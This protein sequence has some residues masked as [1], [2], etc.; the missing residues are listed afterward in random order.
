MSKKNTKAS[1][2]SV[3]NKKM[4]MIEKAMHG[5]D[6][7]KRVSKNYRHKCSKGCNCN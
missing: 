7:G 2:Q 3:A 6:A 4:Q 1:E 5:K